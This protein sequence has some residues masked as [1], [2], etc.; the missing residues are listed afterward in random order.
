M[1]KVEQFELCCCVVKK[2]LHHIVEGDYFSTSALGSVFSTF[3][4][5]RK[6][7]V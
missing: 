6:I 1:I 5:Q 2:Y 4:F 7:K 3:S